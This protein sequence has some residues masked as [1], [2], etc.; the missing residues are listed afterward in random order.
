MQWRSVLLVALGGTIGTGLR[1]TVNIIVPPT[2]GL[3]LK[4][5]VINLI[6][7][8]LL[9]FLLENLSVKGKDVDKRKDIRLFI[10]VGILG[11]FT[12]YSA[13]ASYA[14]YLME[15]HVFYGIIYAFGTVLFGILASFIGILC[16]KKLS[17]K[18]LNKIL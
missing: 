15:T 9:G 14:A 6:G 12:T 2:D 17:Y 13:M 10:G 18:K 16:A 11:G 1:E 3:P 5:I 4:I 8:F 7:A